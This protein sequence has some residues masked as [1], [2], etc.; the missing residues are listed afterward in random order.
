[1]PQCG[2]LTADGVPCQRRTDGN[3]CFMH[4]ASGPP[5]GHGGQL[6]NNNAVGN[7]GGGAPPLNTNAQ[8]HAGFADVDKHYFRLEGD[9]K[10]WVNALAE[11]I[12][13]RSKSD[14][15][16]KERNRLARKIATFHHQWH[17]AVTDTFQ[18]GW[19]LEREETHEPTGKTYTVQRLNPAT[20]ADL[21]ISHRMRRLYRLLRTYSTPDGRPWT[22]W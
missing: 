3:P 10:E 13:E 18:R 4:D 2:E 11:A 9:E 14:F 21:M 19:V 7:A 22:E 16:A 17:C 15:S 20:R 8:I 12:S 5:S 1:M 6:E